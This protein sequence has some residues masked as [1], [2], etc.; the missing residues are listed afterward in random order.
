[1]A[2][3]LSTLQENSINRPDEMNPDITILNGQDVLFN[4]PAEHTVDWLRWHLERGID[5]RLGLS[6]LRGLKGFQ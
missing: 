5:I 1:M 4:N 2:R 6:G 3:D